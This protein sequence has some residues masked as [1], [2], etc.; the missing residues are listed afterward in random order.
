MVLAGLTYMLALSCQFIWELADGDGL[1]HIFQLAGDI[2]WGTSVLF[3]VASPVEI[4]DFLHSGSILRE[5]ALMCK[6]F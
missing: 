6:H 1:A 3:C 4:L 5:Q 2:S